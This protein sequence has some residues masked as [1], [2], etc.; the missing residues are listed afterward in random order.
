M[1][2]FIKFNF[3][4]KLGMFQIYEK[5]SLHFIWKYGWKDGRMEDEA[6]PPILP[7]FQSSNL[8]QCQ[9]VSETC[10]C[11]PESNKL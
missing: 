5:M 9:E 11:I 2:T 3:D 1:K 4:P 8:K 6:L 7:F 10:R